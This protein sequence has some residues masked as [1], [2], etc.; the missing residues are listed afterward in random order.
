MLESWQIQIRR[1]KPI[2]TVM[3]YDGPALDYQNKIT[4]LLF[5]EIIKK[6]GMY[7]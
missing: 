6:W 7:T 5:L 1:P 4:P 3:N 2:L